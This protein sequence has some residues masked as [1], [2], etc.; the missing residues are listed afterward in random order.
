MCA[1][2]G[3]AWY[4]DKI[5]RGANPGGL[6]ATTGHNQTHAPQQTLSDHLIGTGK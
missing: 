3:M 2:T 5:F 4:A 1:S 6:P